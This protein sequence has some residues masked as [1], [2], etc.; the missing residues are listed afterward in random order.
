MSN[1]RAL[2]LVGGY[3]TRLRPFTFTVPK[4]CVPFANKAI[5]LHQIEA[6]VKVGVKEIV[7]AVNVA[8][9]E[10]EDFLKKAE[11]KYG[12]KIHF[13]LETVPLGTAGPLALA[14]KWLGADDSP[15]FMFNSDVIC[16]F[17][18][19]EMLKFH[20]SHGGE[21]TLMVTTVEDPSKYGVII[22]DEKSGQ[23]SQFIEKPKIPISNR[24]NAGLYLLSPAILKRIE[25]KPTSIERDIFPVIAK[26][27]KLYSMLLPGYWM[28][29][30]QP[31][32]YLSGT[33]LH[34]K[35]LAA[36]EPK[37]LA[38]GKLDGKE[39]KAIKGNVLIGQNVTI[40]KNCE[41]GPDVIIGDGCII[42]D[43]VR[44]SRTTLLEGAVIKQS[45]WVHSSIIGW[46]STVGDWARVEG[47]SIGEDVQ[48]AREICLNEVIVLPHKGVSANI[49]Q[50]GTIIM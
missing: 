30:G 45:A 5:V 44:L 16:E 34:L 25:E 8:P 48:V 27:Q 47:S 17:P 1:L 26:E 2:I 14:K 42:G 7:M 49:F 19:A 39:N 18:L 22:A 50:P 46:K 41:I 40:G 37:A 32:D 3:G 28:D 6:L 36:H 33:V 21:G 15:F 23:I 4:P 12:I 9:K 35:H 10:M 38:D 31:K 11:A 24:I 20:K 29:I 13:S 43:G